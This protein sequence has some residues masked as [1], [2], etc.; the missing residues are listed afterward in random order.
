MTELLEQSVLIF[1]FQK[2]CFFTSDVWVYI[3]STRCSVYNTV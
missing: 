1:R 3:H 2:Y